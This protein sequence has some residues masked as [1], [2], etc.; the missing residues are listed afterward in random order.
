MNANK[1]AD[2]QKKST[3]TLKGQ[4]FGA[5]AMMLVAA[6]ALGTST[7]A[8]FIN[9]RAVTVEDMKLTVSASSSMLVALEKYDAATKTGAGAY[10]GYKSVIIND[11]IIGTTGTSADQ[12]GWTEFLKQ[13]MVPA[14]ITDDSLKAAAPAFYATNNHVSN[15]LLDE[16]ELVPSAD[17]DSSGTMV[18][19]LGQ[20]P[21]KKL[22]LR[23]VSSNDLDVFF[24]KDDIVKAIGDMIT[25]VHVK[26]QAEIDGMAEGDAKTAAQAV[27]DAETD[28][29]DEIKA[30]LRVA[31]VAQESGTDASG[32]AKANAYTG[33]EYHTFQFDA[34]APLVPANKNNTDYSY[35]SAGVV[36]AD[37]LAGL[38]KAISTVDANKHITQDAAL[39]AL[40]P[41]LTATPAKNADNAMAVIKDG[42]VTYPAADAIKLF[43]LT[44][45]VAR[46]VDVYIWLEGTDQDCLNGISGYN[47]NLKLPFVGADKFVPAP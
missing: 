25:P 38:Y 19:G 37:E 13:D 12:A 16:F 5:V 2:S 43:S 34:G 29:A 36:T 46:D 21:V 3:K 33:V 11:D 28:Q 15:G 32:S 9:N 31:V 26:T 17:D 40:V 10:T 30:A 7:Y 45:D 22:G 20:G 4:L 8:W 44:K 1:P 41:G 24:G 42:E 39:N 14:S 18:Y 35:V 6:I 47:F 23:F 27:F